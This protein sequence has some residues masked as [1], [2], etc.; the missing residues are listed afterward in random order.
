MESVEALPCSCTRAKAV[1]RGPTYAFVP[2]Q[3][4]HDC[5]SGVLVWKRNIKKQLRLWQPARADLGDQQAWMR[6]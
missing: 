1:A 3:P 4:K 6:C 2:S 5:A